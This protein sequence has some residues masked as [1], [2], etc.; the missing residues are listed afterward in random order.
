MKR[1]L[2]CHIFAIALLP[3]P[4]AAQ[5]GLVERLQDVL[6]EDVAAAVIQRIEDARV[7]ELPVQAAANLALE[8]VAKGRSAEEVLA[9]VELLVADMG[10][11]QEAL[12]GGGRAP[13]EGEVEAA[14]AAMRMGVDGE[15]ISALAVSQSS[16]RTLAVALLVMG[17]LTERGLPSDEALAA[18]RDRLSARADDAGL[19][20]DFPGVGQSLAAGM[21]PQDVGAAMA[22]GLAGF[23]V[24]VSGITVP[25]GPPTEN[26]RRPSGRGRGAGPGGL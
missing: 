2:R 15:A 13:E 5:Q 20:G 25:V 14:A 1:I 10:R 23:Q 11:A 9:A 6:P 18:V 12:Q 4:A 21:P 3:L 7:R 8:G 17:G 26:A 22:G 24:P 19:L 16:G